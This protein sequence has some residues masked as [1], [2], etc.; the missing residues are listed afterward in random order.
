MKELKE[1]SEQIA[2]ARAAEDRAK[3]AEMTMAA[4]QAELNIANDQLVKL[5]IERDYFRAMATD[6]CTRAQVI[7]DLTL[8]MIEKSAKVARRQ[9]V[10]IARTE[11]KSDEQESGPPIA[12]R[13]EMRAAA[14]GIAPI[15][16]AKG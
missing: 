3:A 8:D 4:M 11:A 1:V 9:L 16:W 12:A 7:S 14:A 2:R 5:T 15:E 13:R 6:L 10:D